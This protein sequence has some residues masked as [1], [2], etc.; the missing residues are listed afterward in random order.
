MDILVELVVCRENGERER[1]L[2]RRCEASTEVQGVKSDL[3]K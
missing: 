1:S 2:R 3:Q